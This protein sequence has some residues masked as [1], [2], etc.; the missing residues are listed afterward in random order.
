MNAANSASAMWIWSAYIGMSNDCLPSILLAG[1]A[2]S[3]LARTPFV[4]EY[5]IASAF[6]VILSEQSRIGCSVAIK[7][8]EQSQ[9]NWT[10]VLATLVPRGETAPELI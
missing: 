5:L 3:S 9:N 8:E 7:P 6:L 1:D 2:I 10:I 4:L